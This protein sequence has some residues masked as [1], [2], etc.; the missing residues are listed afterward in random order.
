[1][2]FKDLSKGNKNLISSTDGTGDL[3]LQ[4]PA[5]ISLYPDADQS[6]GDRIVWLRDGGKLIFEGTYPDD[7]EAKLQATVLTADRELVLPDASGTIALTVDVDNVLESTTTYI[8]ASLSTVQ[9]DILTTIES[10]KVG[11]LWET[12]PSDSAIKTASVFIENGVQTGI[13]NTTFI[14]GQ[15]QLELAK[16]TPTLTFNYKIG[17][18]DQGQYYTRDPYWDEPLTRVSVRVDNP[19]DYLNQWIASVDYIGSPVNNLLDEM[20]ASD[21]NPYSPQPGSYWNQVFTFDPGLI[22]PGALPQPE[23]QGA[24]LQAI[25][26]VGFADNNG[27]VTNTLYEIITWQDLK[28]NITLSP[29]SGKTF[30]DTYTTTNYT[31]NYTGILDHSNVTSFV[32]TSD[33]LSSESFYQP[34]DNIV[35]NAQGDGTITFND[36]IHKDSEAQ[37]TIT[38]TLSATRPGTVAGLAQPYDV[39][40]YGGVDDYIR[41]S[42]DMVNIQQAAE[43]TYPSFYIFT[44]SAVPQNSD[45]VTG[46]TFSS[47]VTVLG[48]YAKSLATTI[49]N[50]SSIPRVF[51]FGVLDRFWVAQ[52]TVFQTGASSSLL[53]DV[54]VQRKSVMLYNPDLLATNALPETYRLYGITL[55][56]GNTYV[57]IN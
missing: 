52:P 31:A 43:F 53:S 38:A 5:G 29:L 42:N 6:T 32:V 9:N 20:V 1:M 54:T 8:D 16:F 51:W 25:I 46:N 56:P 3:L 15:L 50:T 41:G 22:R 17:Y 12:D 4:S 19:V 44:D 14:N 35:S 24:G 45:I 57:R 34:R 40:V 11:I 21:P 27:N 36:P 49:N 26:P 39:E 55:Q 7:W 10:E 47:D 13:R 23:D 33:M 28:V 18:F 48:H 37:I 2:A 30:L